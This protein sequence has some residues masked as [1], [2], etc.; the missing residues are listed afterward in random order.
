VFKS[1]RATQPTKRFY[2]RLALLLD[3]QLL[4]LLGLLSELLAWDKVC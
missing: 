4:L 3:P 1:A 2:N